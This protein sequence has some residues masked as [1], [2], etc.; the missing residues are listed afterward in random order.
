MN[1]EIAYY[2]LSGNTE[3]LAYGIAKR[4]PE[5]QAFLTNLQEVTLAADVYLVGFGINNGT[6]PLKVMDALDRLAGKKIFL[7]VTCGIEPSE[8]YK[9]LIERKI[10]PFLPDECDYCG[11]L[12][13]KIQRQ[14]AQQPDDPAIKK[15]ISEAKLSEGHPDE[16]DAENAV[17]FIREKLDSF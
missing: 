13:S 15:M 12:L 7:F 5:N 10:E 9:R 6:V 2:S 16:T 17:R 14:F 4:L 3:K 1:Y 8:E 11:I